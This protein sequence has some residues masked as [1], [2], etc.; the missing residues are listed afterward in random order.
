MSE[1]L[2]PKMLPNKTLTFAAPLEVEPCV[3]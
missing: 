1:V 2:I 3:V